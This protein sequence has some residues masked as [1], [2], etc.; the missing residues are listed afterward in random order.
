MRRM[1]RLRFIST[2]FIRDSDIDAYHKIFV[3]MNSNKS[4][5]L[6]Y[7]EGVERVRRGGYAYFL[8]SVQLD[9]TM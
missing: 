6:E 4:N 8:E 1:L 3:T 7:P 5:L 2:I 9:Y